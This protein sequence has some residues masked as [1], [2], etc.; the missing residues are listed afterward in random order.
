MRIF[1][2]SNLQ[3]LDSARRFVREAARILPNDPMIDESVEQLQLAVTEAVA[4]IIK[5]A[6]RGESENKIEV[7]AESVGD[8][9]QIALHHWGDGVDPTKVPPPV[10]DGSK[11][12]GFGVFII[13]NCVDFVG[14]STDEQNRNTI[15][16]IKNSK[17]KR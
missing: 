4:N 10:F 11:D 15:L 13:Q 3:E 7:V 17:N 9:I 8:D 5:H 2:K 16:L 1:L 6:Y 14:Y 12:G